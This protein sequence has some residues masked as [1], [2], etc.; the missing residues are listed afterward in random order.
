MKQKSPTG[1]L[2]REH[3]AIQRVIGTM[4][5]LAAALER[6]GYVKVGTLLETVEF[7]CTFADQCHHGKEERHVFPLLGRKGAPVTGYPLDALIRDHENTRALIRELAGASE[8]YLQ[9]GPASR[10]PLDERGNP[11]KVKPEK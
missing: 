4:I 1:L 6:G 3:R 5:T 7:M 2:E 11:Q 9:G 8:A 10:F